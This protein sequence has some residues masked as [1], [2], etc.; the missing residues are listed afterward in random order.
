MRCDTLS[1]AALPSPLF[2]F[3][4]S[5]LT[6][7]TIICRLFLI[8]W[9]SSCSSCRDTLVRSRVLVLEPHALGHVFDRQQDLLYVVAGPIDLPR[10]EHHHPSSD[11]R[12]D[13]VHFEGLDRSLV[14]KGWFRSRSATR[15]CPT[16]R[17]RAHRASGRPYPL[18]RLRICRRRN[19]SRSGRSGRDRARAGLH[20]S[21]LRDPVGR[22]RAWPAPAHLLMTGLILDSKNTILLERPRQPPASPDCELVEGVLSVMYIT[23]SVE[24][25][26]F[27]A[28]V[29]GR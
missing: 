14:R 6:M 18:A 17:C 25:S 26:T 5:R 15:E 23:D 11:R 1:S 21:S 24:S 2:W 19:G 16:V 20:G 7:A 22:L 8:R 12:E 4:A 29:L 27:Y 28:Y 13:A 3:R 10:V 9:P